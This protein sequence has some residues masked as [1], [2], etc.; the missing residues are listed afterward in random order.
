VVTKAIA[1]RHTDV[2][3]TDVRQTLYPLRAVDRVCDIIDLLAEHPSGITLSN[4]AATVGLPKSSAFRYL[5]ALEAR[6]YVIRSDDGTGYRLGS[7]VDGA[8]PI[9]PGRLERL[10]TLAKPLMA[11]LTSSDIPVCMLAGRDGI[12]IRYLWITTTLTADPRVPKLGDRGMLHTTAVGKAIASQLADETVLTLVN[13]AGMPQSTPSTLGSPTGLLRELHRIR[14]E[15]FAMSENERHS[16]VRG[17]AVPIGG[18]TIA[19][20]V[21]ARGD[22]LTQD[23]VAGAVRQLRRA[24][25]V[26]ARE[27]RG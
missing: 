15:G 19:L 11:R 16:D 3:P 24:A 7:P 21:A 22:Q 6:G 14:G 8:Q 27:F 17:V 12:G 5:A 26:L 20:G 23:R 10:V 13:T 9:G 1:L 18:E 4:L 2:R 25:V